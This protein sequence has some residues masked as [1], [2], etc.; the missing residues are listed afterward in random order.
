MVFLLN[1]CWNNTIHGIPLQKATGQVNDIS[2]LLHFHW[3][4]PVYYHVDE[5]SFPSEPRE[6]RGHWV[7]IAENAGHAM[8]YKILMDDTKKVI[9][10]SEVCP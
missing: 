5:T 7:G 6:K 9:C 8:T 1:N 3:W 10:H 4:Q 2:P